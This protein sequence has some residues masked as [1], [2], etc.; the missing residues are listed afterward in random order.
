[1]AADQESVRGVDPLGRYTIAGLE[2]PAGLNS[3]V[4]AVELAVQMNTALLNQGV[5]QRFEE[6]FFVTHS[7]G[8]IL[9]QEMLHQ[10]LLSPGGEGAV[11][12][13]TKLGSLYDKTK[14]VFLIATPAEGA[15]LASMTRKLTGMGTPILSD[16]RRIDENSYLRSL[17]NTWAAL[18][19]NG[20]LAPQ[21]ACAYET[22]PTWG[23]VAVPQDKISTNCRG[24]P[25]PA[26]EDHNMIVKPSTSSAAIHGW[27]RGKLAEHRLASTAPNTSQTVAEPAPTHLLGTRFSSEAR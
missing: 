14:L 19:S 5:G 26:A 23:F 24:V 10:A 11:N 17:R 3:T 12:E 9:V 13:K 27:V 7:F 21:L 18:L 1:M 20:K 2:Y 8:G 6:I 16:L 22:V 15:D 4:S 25:F